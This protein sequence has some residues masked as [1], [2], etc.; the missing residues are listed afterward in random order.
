MSGSTINIQVVQDV[1][2]SMTAAQAQKLIGNN[3]WSN[4]KRIVLSNSQTNTTK[5]LK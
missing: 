3:V 1:S 2:C 4:A 5:R